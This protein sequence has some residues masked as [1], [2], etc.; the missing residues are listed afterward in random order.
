MVQ[1]R[2]STLGLCMFI[3]IDRLFGFSV[4]RFSVLAITNFLVDIHLLCL[5]TIADL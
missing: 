5:C 1:D 2:R 4:L 3:W